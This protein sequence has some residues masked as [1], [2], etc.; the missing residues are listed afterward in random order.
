MPLIAEPG[1][2]F[3]VAAAVALALG[4]GA[5]SALFSVVWAVL[6]KP[7]PYHDPDR[8]VAILHGDEVNSPVSPADDLD[9]RRAA[10]SFASMAAA[11]AWSANLA[12]DGRA[13]RVPALQ[14][15]PGC[16][17]CSVSSR[18]WGVCWL[19]PTTERACASSRHRTHAVDAPLRRHPG[20]VGRRVRL[21]GDDYQIVG[22]MPESFRFAPFWQTQAE[23]WVPLDLHARRTDRPG[24]SLRVFARL[25]NGVT[26]DAARAEIRVLNDRLVQ[27]HPIPIAD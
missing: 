27:A 20:I 14:V 11:Q 26:L 13:E 10:R 2:R 5:T 6:L 1:A 4:I 16:S 7:L 12:G 21:N 18:H 3:T 25:A 9:L 22:V 8:L 19:G 23:L 15:T 24:R 17:T